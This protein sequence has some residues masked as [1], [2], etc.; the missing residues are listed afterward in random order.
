[1]KTNQN[2]DLRSWDEHL[3]DKYG[4][5]GTQTRD[6]YEEEFESFR[7]GVFIQEARK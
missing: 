3:D 7:I 6:K 1:M 2:N 4:K 5:A